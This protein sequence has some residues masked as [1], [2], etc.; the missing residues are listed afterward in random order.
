MREK[1]IS[2]LFPR[3]CIN[4]QTP[5]NYLC[6]TCK[7]LLTPHPEICPYCHR[8]STNYQTCLNCKTDKSHHLEWLIVVFSYQN[9][10]KKFILQLKYY[11]KH[12]VADFLTDRLAIALSANSSLS[13]HRSNILISYI[14]SHRFRHYFIKGYNQSKLLAQKLSE[15]IWFPWINIAQKTRSTH[16]QAGLDKSQRLANLQGAFHL[17]NQ[18]ILDTDTILIIDD[19]TT[20]W[21]TI[22]ELAKTIKSQF[23][24]VKIRWAVL[25]RNNK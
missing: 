23:P 20:T 21:S 22:N 18:K 1:F 2:L 3:T 19:V 5:G 25:A 11:H 16:T 7:K 24:K 14:P 12:D 8:F 9:L 4:C 15:K 6:K 13:F 10:I 17:N